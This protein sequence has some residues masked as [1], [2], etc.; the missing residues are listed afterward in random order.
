MMVRPLLVLVVV[1]PDSVFG[2]LVSAAQLQALRLATPAYQLQF[3][4]GDRAV[5]RVV[6]GALRVRVDPGHEV[7]RLRFSPGGSPDAHI[8]PG[9]PNSRQRCMIW[10]GLS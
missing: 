10:H 3:Q 9:N 7:P 1:T 6:L 2:M 8:R 5:E 4:V